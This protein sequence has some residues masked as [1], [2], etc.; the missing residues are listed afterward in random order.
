M[1][2]IEAHDGDIPTADEASYAVRS[3]HVLHSEETST[4]ASYATASSTPRATTPQN[5][6][7]ARV[8]DQTHGVQ[9]SRPYEAASDGLAS[10]TA[11]QWAPTDLD[12]APASLPTT[13]ILG[14]E[15]PPFIA[16]SDAE[17]LPSTDV[18]KE[19]AELPNA[20]TL[21]TAQ[22]PS[23]SDS[24]EK[25]SSGSSMREKDIDLEAGQRHSSSSK[26]ESEKQ[27]ADVDPNIVDW[28]GPDDPANP[29]NWSE[30]LKWG[31]VLI[32]SIITFLTYVNTPLTRYASPTSDILQTPSIL[33]V[34]TRCP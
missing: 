14:H 13:Y 8:A 6:E 32:I 28:D 34:R 12:A 11:A 26:K 23:V 18:G 29:Y 19:A 33:H 10:S 17:A 27:Q 30:G 21:S 20:S 4:A 25:K 15:Q 7:E 24:N 9:I 31:N 1:A 22:A 16:P 3:T 5:L 2:T